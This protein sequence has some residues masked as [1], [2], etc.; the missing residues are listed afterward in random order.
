[1]ARQ[2]RNA[3]IRGD[4]ASGDS[5]RAESHLIAQYEVSRPSIR[6]AVR[7]LESEGLVTVT[8]GARGGARVCSPGFEQIQRAAGITLQAQ[9]VT[10]G[11][12]YEMHAIMGP[13]AAR[14]V[15]ERSREAAV[16]ALRALI[17]DLDVLA[18]DEG[19]AIAAVAR[20]HRV[21]VEMAG[22]KTLLVITQALAAL[23]IAHVALAHRRKAVQDSA[24]T[25]RQLRFG[26]R[27]L[28]RLVDLIEA[29]DGSG[30][31][32]HWRAHM[33]AAGEVWMARVGSDAIV[34]LID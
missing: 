21:L 23:G 20:F 16:P 11:D 32:A 4:L 25:E 24:F 7:I 30:A 27:S 34:N 9:G 33:A 1:V 12:I 26:L 19:A 5:L 8:R 17:A 2:I 14:L 29:G 28:A 15:A 13:P 10:I 18:K 22:N 3:I 6:E 31:E